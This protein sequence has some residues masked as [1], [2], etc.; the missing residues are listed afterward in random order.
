MTD[1]VRQPSHLPGLAPEPPLLLGVAV[2][3]T[4]S[5]STRLGTPWGDDP[6]PRCTPPHSHTHLDHRTCRSHVF[7]RVLGSREHRRV[8]APHRRES[9]LSSHHVGVAF[10]RALLGVH[11]AVHTFL[12]TLTGTHSHLR[13][14]LCSHLCSHWC[15]HWC[16]HLSH[17]CSRLCSH[18]CSHPGS[19][20]NSVGVAETAVGVAEAT[21]NFTL[22]TAHGVVES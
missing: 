5:S 3:C 22:A 16:S 6:E 17:L 8:T 1:S 18:L 7:T 2:A 14:H 10:T 4:G 20:G 9:V 12:H 13:S 11:T 15:S 19:A 21:G